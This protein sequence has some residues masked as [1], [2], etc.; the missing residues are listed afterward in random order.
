MLKPKKGDWHKTLHLQKV[1][2]V[3]VLS[4]SQNLLLPN[5]AR[6]IELYKQSPDVSEDKATNCLDLATSGK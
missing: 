2:Q 5:R 4:S 6:D 3:S 1:M